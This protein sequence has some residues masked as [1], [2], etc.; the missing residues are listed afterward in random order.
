M[1]Y[2]VR[3]ITRLIETDAALA[4]DVEAIKAALGVGSAE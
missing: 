2:S 3:K 4:A 1:I